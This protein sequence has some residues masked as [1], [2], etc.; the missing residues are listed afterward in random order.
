MAP[1]LHFVLVMTYHSLHSALVSIFLSTATLEASPT[2][3]LELFRPVTHSELRAELM[4]FH[5]S[6]KF[7]TT[8][9]LNSYKNIIGHKFA[10]SLANLNEKSHW[11][12]A[13]GGEGKAVFD[14][15]EA[16]GEAMVTLL[17][18]DTEQN[19]RDRLSVVKGRLLEEIPH[20]ELGKFELITD[21]YGP[22]AYSKQPDLVLSKYLEMLV[23]GGKIFTVTDSRIDDRGGIFLSGGRR[24][25]FFEWLKSTKG[26]RVELE[27][28]DVHRVITIER[29]SNFENIE[30][31]TGPLA[32]FYRVPT[33]PPYRF[34]GEA[35]A[36]PANQEMWAKNLRIFQEAILQLRPLDSQR[37][38]LSW[39][40]RFEGGPEDHW[41][42]LTENRPEY[43]EGFT[44][45][46][47]GLRN[48]DLQSQ[49]G[50]FKGKI[51]GLF[52]N[53]KSWTDNISLPEIYLTIKDLPRNS[54]VK[55]LS[56]V[57]G[58]FL[59]GGRPDL[60]LKEYLEKLDDDGK[61]LL[62]IPN[63]HNLNGISTLDPPMVLKKDAQQGFRYIEIL[64]WLKEIPGLQVENYGDYVSIIIKDRTNVHISE[65]QFLGANEISPLPQLFF[66]EK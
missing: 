22:F 41:I 1:L 37:S 35:N 36:R 48:Q 9:D 23:P 30:F 8:R 6:K 55:Y 62:Y 57:F 21:V 26:I 25:D 61:L 20:S 53:L 14:Y 38:L 66:I 15:H 49:Q 17:S 19:S 59:K 27:D 46:R 58:P 34:L 40:G 3:C 44:E 63:R 52:H 10:E 29:D 16:R 64:Q 33:M 51:K 60:V 50:T 4:Q 47:E 54:K 32:E 18:V 13:G 28:R 11:L 7:I 39:R 12:E 42:H 2:K 31:P 56:D 24:M 45:A 43:T 65:L 5:K